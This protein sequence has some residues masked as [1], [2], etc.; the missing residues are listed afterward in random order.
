M[1]Y[2]A[3]LIELKSREKNHGD[4]LF[5]VTFVFIPS[6][7]IW[8]MRDENAECVAFCLSRDMAR[9]LIVVGMMH[10]VQIFEWH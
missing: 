7:F 4:V 3:D 8:G 10:T 9:V 1:I 5:F 2:L 6:V